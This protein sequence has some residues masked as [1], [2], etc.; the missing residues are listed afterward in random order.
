MLRP[1]PARSLLGP[2]I[3]IGIVFGLAAGWILDR[4]Q[5]SKAGAP[6]A[7][8]S[9]EILAT[10]NPDAWAIPTK[11]I[12][13]G[14][15]TSKVRTSPK[16]GLKAPDFSLPD[17]EGKTVRLSDLRG[18]VVVIN[19][20]ASWC[21]PCRAEMPDLQEVSEKYLDEGLVVLG[22]NTTYVDK[23]ADALAFIDELKLTFPILFDESG[24]VGEDNYSV[25]SLP[26]SYWIDRSGTIQVIHVGAMSRDQMIDLAEM[27]LQP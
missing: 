11:A 3:L 14:K 20:W 19:F 10:L 15:V 24:D 21:L 27:F 26:T 9:G 4:T 18:K 16:I 6:P 12:T 7:D 2:L 23:R 1:P 25:I 13:P 22:V 5:T 17:R 8:F